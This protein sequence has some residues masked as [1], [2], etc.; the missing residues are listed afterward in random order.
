MEKTS[1]AELGEST[2]IELDKEDIMEVIQKRQSGITSCYEK[3]LQTNRT[4]KGKVMVSFTIQV[5]GEVTDVKVN[6]S[7]SDLKEKKVTD[8]MVLILKNLRFPARKKGP[9]QEINFPFNFKPKAEQ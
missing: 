9:P 5:S 8:C 1:G 6:E 2:V 3:E 4:L 7:K